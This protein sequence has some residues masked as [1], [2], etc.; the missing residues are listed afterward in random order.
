MATNLIDKRK[1]DWRRLEDL[2]EQ[3]RSREGLR[4]LT[5]HEVREFGRIYRRAAADLAIARVESRDQRVVNYLNNLVIRTHG[6]IYRTEK[7][8][9]QTILGF[10][11]DQFPAIFRQ[12][13]RYTLAVMATFLVISVFAF[14]GTVRDEAFADFSSISPELLD[15]IRANQPWWEDLNAQAADGA[16]TIIANNAGIGLKTFALS[17]FPL[18][19]TILVLLPSALM[20]GSINALILKYG[21][22]GKLWSFMIGHIVLEFAAIFIAGGAGLM[23]GLALLVPGKHTRREALVERGL[24]AIRLLAGCLPL[25]LLA[26][27]VEAFISP[28]PINPIFKLIVSFTT[29]TA[30][31]GYLLSHPR[32]GS[33]L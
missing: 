24:L 28:L 4:R 18:A 23:I 20:F 11:R 32:S 33:V 8:G 6:V 22:T 29:I 13:S 1:D 9:W 31:T 21:M 10:Y 30:L 5:R 3:A 17:I 15:N 7:S 25:F 2:L 16:V 27:L 14:V 26:G 19:G 12:T